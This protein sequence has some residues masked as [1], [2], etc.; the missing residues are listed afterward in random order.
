VVHGF[1][2]E[3]ICCSLRADFEAQPLG[4]P[5]FFVILGDVNIDVHSIDFNRGSK[6]NQ[7]MTCPQFPFTS[8]YD[9]FLLLPLRFEPGW[10]SAR[11]KGTA[12]EAVTK[13]AVMWFKFML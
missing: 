13:P 5:T 6:L 8:E 10:G 7:L 4:L 11:G 12:F 1:I 2:A 9:N 3:R